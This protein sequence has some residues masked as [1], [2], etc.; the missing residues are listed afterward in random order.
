M[1]RGDEG[2]RATVEEL[3]EHYAL[4]TPVVKDAT[5]VATVL[6]HT[7]DH[8]KDLVMIFTDTCKRTQVRGGVKEG[9]LGGESVLPFFIFIDLFTYIFSLILFYLFI[10]FH[11][12][13]FIYY[14]FFLYIIFRGQNLKL[15]IYILRGY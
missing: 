3:T 10:L 1:W 6:R 4:V 14:I 7:E 8:P 5:L 12:Y 11:L 2:G 15:V 9:C 13:L